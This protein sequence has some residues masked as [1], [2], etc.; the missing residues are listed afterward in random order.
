MEHGNASSTASD[1]FNY[2][3]LDHLPLLVV[4]NAS[5]SDSNEP[6]DGYYT[7]A[8][9]PSVTGSPAQVEIPVLLRQDAPFSSTSPPT[10][11]PDVL[12]LALASAV[13]CA[14]AGAGGASEAGGE[15]GGASGA[16]GG[17]GGSG[18][19]LESATS[20]RTESGSDSDE[21]E[22][23]QTTSN[24]TTDAGPSSSSSSLPRIRQRSAGESAHDFLKAYLGGDPRFSKSKAIRSCRS[25]LTESGWHHCQWHY[26]NFEGEN[27]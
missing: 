24:T 10:A 19:E 26:C 5:A 25:A 2:E 20:T 1:Y 7:P 21:V 16:G 3:G 11:G 12:L 6:I 14:D 27:T 17:A 22:Y 8:P 4:E 15:A 18:G 23:V 9:P 13:S